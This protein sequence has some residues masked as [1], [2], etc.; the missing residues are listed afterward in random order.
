MPG[1]C[2]KNPQKGISIQTG[3]YHN[4]FLF[5]L[6]SPEWHIDCLLYLF[7]SEECRHKKCME[8]TSVVAMFEKVQ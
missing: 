1:L 3:H 5:S 7:C 4:C 6:Y 8:V 2:E